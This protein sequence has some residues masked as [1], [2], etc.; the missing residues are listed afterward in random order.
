MYRNQYDT[1]ATTFSPAGRLHQVEYAMEAVKQ[2]S[3]CVGLRS[4]DYV[5]VASLKRAQSELSSF[6]KKVFKVDDHL[7]IASSGLISDARVLWKYMIQECLNHK[8]VYGTPLPASRLVVDISDKAQV[9]TQKSEKRPYGVGFL[10]AAYDATG[11][12]LFQTDP[13]GNYFEYKAQSMGARSQTSKTYL[14][15]H[16]ETFET[17]SLDELVMHALISLKGA[18]TEKLTSRNVSVGFVGKDRTFTVLEDEDIKSYVDRVPDN[19]GPQQGTGFGD[20][21]EEKKKDDMD[22]DSD[23]RPPAPSGPA[24]ELVSDIPAGMDD[25]E[26]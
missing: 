23:S 1:D 2:G 16:F 6:Q 22:V 4:K 12:H 21:D 7:G 8:F 19:E 5:I 10:I 18:A 15:K 25:A 11:P 17:L 24:S 26:T 20:E 13:S 14:E 3:A 9:F